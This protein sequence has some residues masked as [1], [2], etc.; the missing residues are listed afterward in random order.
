ML[1]LRKAKPVLYFARFMLGKSEEQNPARKEKK[2]RGG[3][4]E[5]GKEKNHSYFISEVIGEYN[6][7]YQAERFDV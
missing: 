7:R 4:G 6:G 2:K 5:G 1:D 3:W